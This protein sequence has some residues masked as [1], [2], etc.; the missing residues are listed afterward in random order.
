MASHVLSILG[1]PMAKIVRRVQEMRT[2]KYA[3]MREFFHGDDVNDIEKPDDVRKR[4]SC[5]TLQD[6]SYAIG[7][8]LV[9]LHLREK[10][11][12]LHKN[13]RDDSAVVPPNSDE[14]LKSG[15]VL[16]L[17]GTPEDLEHAEGFLL[18]G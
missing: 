6:N 7:K 18:N 11:I 9:D 3:T 14:E 10:G 17:F 2:H 16:V 1:M 15:D 13:R 5:I 4:L 12:T 8:K